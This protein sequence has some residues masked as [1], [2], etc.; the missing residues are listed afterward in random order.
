MRLLRGTGPGGAARHPPGC[1]RRHPSLCWDRRRRSSPSFRNRGSRGARTPP[2]DG[3]NLRARLRREVVPVLRDIFGDGC[4]DSPAR[5]AALLERICV[6]SKASPPGPWPWSPPKARRRR[7]RFPGSR[8]D[9]LQAG[10]HGAIAGA[11]AAGS[12]PPWPGACCAPG[13]GRRSPAAEGT[14][15]ARLAKVHADR[16]SAGCGEA[17]SGSG[18]DLP[19]GRR[20]TR[21]FDRLLPGTAA[22]AAARAAGDGGRLPRILVGRRRSSGRPGRAQTPDGPEPGGG[23]AARRPRPDTDAHLGTDL[24][25]VRAARQPAGA[26]LAPR[27]PPAPLGAGRRQEGERPAARGAR[28]RVR[29]ARAC[30]S[31]RTTTASCG[32][33][34]WPVTSVRGCCRTPT[35]TVTISHHPHGITLRREER[36]LMSQLPGRPRPR[37][38]RVRG[39]QRPP[40]PKG[41]NKGSGV[42]PPHIPG[43]TAGFWV[44][45]LFL[46][47]LVYQMIALDH[48]ID[49]GTDLFDVP[50]AGG[51]GQHPERLQDEPD[52]HRRAARRRRR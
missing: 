42:K 15:G 37:E 24:P 8:R 1:R 20:L 44:L 28:A 2:T 26:R 29:G 45:L 27:R 43:K 32:W 4:L 19:G 38:R 5:L 25:G 17:I 23:R 13:C 6:C 16:S 12:G 11:G 51:K 49:P 21:E 39:P 3:D 47:F 46:V 10:A 41:P 36:A 48:T 22:R 34:G 50:R 35:G 18:L 33:S 40:A 52:R 9:P 7:P 30:W 31:S 14:L